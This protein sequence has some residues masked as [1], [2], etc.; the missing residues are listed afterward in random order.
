MRLENKAR[1]FDRFRLD[2]LIGAGRRGCPGQRPTTETAEHPD[3]IDILILKIWTKYYCFENGAGAPVET[4][5]SW[6]K[7]D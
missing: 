2:F 4:D 6:K 7:S 1:G 5:A 3:M